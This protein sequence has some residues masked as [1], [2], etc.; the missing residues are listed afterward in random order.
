MRVV[1]ILLLLTLCAVRL[2]ADCALNVEIVLWPNPTI[3]RF[4]PGKPP[5]DLANPGVADSTAAIHAD[6]V[7]LTGTW[8]GET[9]VIQGS[10][11]ITVRGGTRLRLPR[12]KTG[13]GRHEEGHDAL[14]KWCYEREARSIF[15]NTLRGLP[16]VYTGQTRDEALAKAAAEVKARI[17]SALNALVKR[18]NDVSGKYDALTEHGASSTVDSDRGVALAKR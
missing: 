9:Y 4:D 11:V 14:F 10:A 16:S 5:A 13:I 3:E 17:D 7:A 18:M 6:G 1:T 8:D 12:G 2:T 15:E